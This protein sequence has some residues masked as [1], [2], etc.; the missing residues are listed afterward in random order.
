MLVEAV[1]HRSFLPTGRGGK[2][3]RRRHSLTSEGSGS[4]R[5]SCVGVVGERKLGSRV[6]GEKA[7]RGEVLGLRSPW[8]VSRR[9]RRP[10]SGGGVLGQ[11]HGARTATWSA[12]GTGGGAVG[13]ARAR[14]GE[15]ASAARRRFR[16]RPVGTAFN[17]P[18]AFGYRHPRQPIRARREATLPLTARPHSLAFSVLKFT[19]GRKYLKINS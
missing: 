1:A 18:G 10:D 6:P 17:P 12:S 3:D 15:A 9:R 5:Q 14:R 13:T 11:G 16:T 7:A 4:R 2:P 8:R 19:P